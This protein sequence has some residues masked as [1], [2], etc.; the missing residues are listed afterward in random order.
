M[1]TL[2]ETSLAHLLQSNDA[3]RP[4]QSPLVK[5]ILRTKEA[6]LATLA[7][8]ISK[9]QFALE[10]LQSTHTHLASEINQYNSILA[11]I[12]RL[13]PEIVGE[14]FLYFVPSLH[15]DFRDTSPDRRVERPWKLGHICRLWRTIALSLGQ[16]WSVVDISA[17]DRPPECRV[18]RLGAYDEQEQEQDLKNLPL[19]T[20]VYRHSEYEEGYE[21]ET[22]LDF[23]RECVERSGER[24]LSF[25]LNPGP[26]Q[27]I[28]LPLFE[29][30]LKHSERWREIALINPPQ[31]LLDRL[32]RVAV[33]F[34]QL[35][36]IVFAHS[37]RFDFFYHSATNLSDLTLVEVEMPPTD[38][39]LIPWS[40]LTRY[41]EID[42]SWPWAS[43]LERVAS[44]RQLTNLDALCLSLSSRDPFLEGILVETRILL[45]NLRVASFRSCSS[46]CPMSDFTKFLDMPV[47]EAFSI[48][49][50]STNEFNLC[51]P[52]FSPHLKI[53]RVQIND[54]SARDVTAER[55]LEMFPDLTEITLDAPDLITDHAI[56]RLTPRLD[57]S[58]L[59]RQLEII[60]FANKSFVNK[61]CKWTTLVEMLQA[62]FKP[63]VDGVSPL[64]LFE[65]QPDEWVNDKMVAASLKALKVQTRWDIRVGDWCKMPHWD[66]LHLQSPWSL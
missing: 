5:K 39:V 64:R 33:H 10:T 25:R 1:A 17:T 16:L 56:S 42:C 27:A 52:D 18:R 13:P 36:K 15:H 35:Q 37:Y 62:R 49:G 50:L 51:L 48:H 41:C 6:E 22:F 54:L 63:T 11:P 61:N 14:V 9:L 66:D 57:Q 53:L 23:I 38:S 40:R 20:D 32:P 44:Y 2:A 65:F 7:A 24:P 30:L 34:Q 3:P 43:P 28:V 47:L 58:P 60:R 45:P 46:L 59:C 8:E 31:L 19:P 4:N 26:R 21:I 29:E 12:R 55:A